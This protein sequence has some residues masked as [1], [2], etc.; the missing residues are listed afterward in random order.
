M[1]TP[2]DADV[3]AVVEDDEAWAG[4]FATEDAGVLLC[5]GLLPP[6]LP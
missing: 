5:A 2:L 4:V 6:A 1:V 3:L